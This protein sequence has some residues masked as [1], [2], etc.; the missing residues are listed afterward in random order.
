[1]RSTQNE[2][3]RGRFDGPLMSSIREVTV[4]DIGDF[5]DIP[6][7]EILVKPG[8][9][10]AK[11]APLVTLESEKAT[12]DIPSPTNGTIKEIKIAV[13]E[14]VSLGSRLLTL[15]EVSD[16]VEPTESPSRPSIVASLPSPSA[17][18]LHPATEEL[19][20]R[21]VLER[22]PY[23]SP[24]TRRFARELGV[25]LS[26]VRGTGRRGRIVKED[27]QE[28]VKTS[29]LASAA[30]ANKDG[31]DDPKSPPW[32]QIDFSKFGKIERVPLS[33]IRR[34]AGMKLARSAAVIP[35]VTNFEDADITDLEAFRQALNAEM[36]SSSVKFTLV[37]FA[38]KATAVTLAKYPEFNSSLEGSELVVK[39]YFHIG[40]AVDTPNGLVVP[41]IRDVDRKGLEEIASEV[42]SLANQARAGKLTP[43][44]LQGG[45]FTISSLGGIGST[46]FT[47]IINAPEVAILGVA[48]AQMRPVWSEKNFH[49]RLILPL[50]L[51][52]DHRVVDGAAAARFLAHVSGLLADFRRVTL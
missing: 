41:V 2:L 52:W 1:M 33:R 35:H 12:L 11:D 17:A 44:D 24:S 5:K 49:P 47:P 7:I 37:T 18:T 28:F 14:R 20:H 13:G 31:Q 10:V 50:S 23:A 19:T 29:I 32:P 48:R 36:R 42:A 38:I 34:I 40:F 16:Q 22:S 46:G 25:D 3:P 21:V 39:H 4:P 15:E 43:A 45:S 8:D 27:L 30:I 9:W 6:I 51:S 26:A